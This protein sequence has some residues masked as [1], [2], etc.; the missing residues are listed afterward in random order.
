MVEQVL[1]VSIQHDPDGAT[2]LVEV[3]FTGGKFLVSDDH[4]MGTGKLTTIEL[5]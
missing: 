2:K 5:Y 3:F 4:T 1:K